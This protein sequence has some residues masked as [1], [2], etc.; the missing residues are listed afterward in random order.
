MDLRAFLP[1]TAWMSLLGAFLLGGMA[2]TAFIVG[3]G[4]HPAMSHP[5]ES[6]RAVAAHRWQPSFA[7]ISGTAFAV[8]PGMLVT[9]AHVTLRCKA[10]NLSMNVTGHA[11]PWRAANE[12][13]NLDLALLA[14]SARSA[15]P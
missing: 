1:P 9:N 3:A 6:D 10:A 5:T 8:A 12:D 4:T 13:R 11:G 7:H 15:I 14:G 2:S